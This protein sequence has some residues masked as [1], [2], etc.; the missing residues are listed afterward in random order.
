M[1]APN[2]KI[3]EIDLSTRVPSFP[4]V[5]GGIVIPATKG[6]VNEA[7]L[8][9]SDTD[10]LKKYTPN[11]KIDVGM[12][13]AY[14]SA[15]AFLAKSNT[16]WVVR[17]ANAALYGGAQFFLN[18]SGISNSGLDA[19]EDDLEDTQ[20]F[21]SG[22]EEAFRLF[23]ANP[24]LWNNDISVKLL[25]YKTNESILAADITAS[26]DQLEVAQDWSTGR[27]V[28]FTPSTGVSDV[29]P[30]GL[31]AATTYY[32]IR[33]DA[34]TIQLATSYANAILGT[35][36]SLTDE[37]VGT[38]TMSPVYVTKEPSSFIIEV[39]KDDTLVE[40]WT[41]SRVA[42]AKDGNGIGI[43]IEDLLESSDYIRA[44]DNL[45][46]AEAAILQDQG[47]ALAF[48]SGTDGGTVADT[49]MVTALDALANPQDKMVTV[50][51]DGAWAT[52]TYHAALIAVAE[53]RKDCV[54]IL[55]SR[56]EDDANS[57]YLNAIIDYRKIVLNAN[58]SY[59][60][61][62]APSPKIYDRYND[63]YL[64]VGA[65]GYAAAAISE[66]AANYEMWYPP[67][68]PRRGKINVL[69]LRRRFTGGV[70]GGGEM[71]ALYDAGINPISFTPGKGIRIWGQKTLLGRPSALDRL[72]VRLL[73]IVLEPAIK[74]A[75]EDFLFELND[76]ATRAMVVSMIKSY[77]ENI[78]ARRGVID[79][80]VTCDATNNS[81]NDV[82]NHILNVWLFVKPSVSIEYITFSCIIT[83]TGMSF[84][85]AAQAL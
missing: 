51:M 85:L 84:N 44:I 76:T 48:T 69:D 9:T 41:C 66:T 33:V 28:R 20:T 82:D 32:V 74:E 16:L 70:D 11:D 77:M 56:Y 61:M 55:S 29:L 53:A 58:S 42:G 39:Y 49:H 18:S 68:G 2:V 6:N 43:Y 57:D 78:K 8:V 36:I 73:L 22:G 71:G 47:A 67:A 17:A 52:A 34:G 15:L 45:D 63:R 7:V 72:N 13:N 23:G 24:G 19:G 21:H 64:Y 37:G 81:D 14:F 80:Q 65:D 35:A 25:T 79:Y 26:S 5:Y 62:F 30:G 3:K 75:L 54:A 27:A 40:T 12:D 31:S 60:A 46:V 59:A 1:A 50:L 4:G 83:R 10:L 38:H